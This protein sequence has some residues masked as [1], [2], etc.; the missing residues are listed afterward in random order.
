MTRCSRTISSTSASNA[1]TAA[2][3]S[4]TVTVSFTRALLA[5]SNACTHRTGT[6]RRL[7]ACRFLAALAIV[8]LAAC[9]GD[10]ARPGNPAVY[11]RIGGLTD[12]AMLQ[13]EFDL[14]M[15]N[16]DRAPAGTEER[17][18]TLAYAQAADDRMRKI[19]CYG[20]RP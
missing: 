4:S 5:F 15:T 14:A 18:W 6:L 19:G 20:P 16:H 8:F 2:S 11:D 10:S 9:A 3:R 7:H 12:C 1:S 13:T 17:R